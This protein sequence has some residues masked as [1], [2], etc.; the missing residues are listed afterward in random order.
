M[1]IKFYGKIKKMGNIDGFGQYKIGGTGGGGGIS[2]GRMVS[3][4]SFQGWREAPLPFGV[5][6]AT[7]GAGGSGAGGLQDLGFWVAPF[8]C[9]VVSFS[10]R[11][12]H[13]SQFRNGGNNPIIGLYKI[14]DSAWT[15]ALD[16]GNTASWGS[17]LQTITIP[18]TGATNDYWKLT[19]SEASVSLSAGDAIA[20]FM[21]VIPTGTSSADSVIW[22]FLN[23]T[24]T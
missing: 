11:W 18:N 15:G 21:D 20:S 6:M 5:P 1:Q 13:N 16:I 22:L 2:T 17:A 4:A 12:G 9:T 8:A 19:S 14:T 10:A 23:Y 3:T 24:Y 7:W